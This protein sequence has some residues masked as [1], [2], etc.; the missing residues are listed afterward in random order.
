MKTERFL[1]TTSNNGRARRQ[2]WNAS[3][4]MPLDYPFRW[5]IERTE[6]G[7][8]PGPGQ[9]G[10]PDWWKKVIVNQTGDHLK[11]VGAPSH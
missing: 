11:M 2:V 3:N 1:I 8:P 7:M 4:P 5:V 6:T 10:Y 9:P